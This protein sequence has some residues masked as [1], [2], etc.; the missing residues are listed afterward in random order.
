L[1]KCL[2]LPQVSFTAR[3]RGPCGGIQSAVREQS[4]LL[5]LRR[6]WLASAGLNPAAVGFCKADREAETQINTDFFD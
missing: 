3:L 6:T 2:F 4:A 5:K 1:F